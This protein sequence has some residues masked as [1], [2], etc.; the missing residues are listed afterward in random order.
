MIIIRQKQYSLKATRVLA[1]F[2]KTVRRM[3]P[4][5]AKRAALNTEK[6]AFQKIA[7][8]KSSI[9][10][11][12]LDPGAAADRFTKKAVESPIA[13]GSNVAGKA[14]MVAPVPV[15]VK[16]APIGAGGIAAE[17]ILKRKVPVYKN[18]T[19]KLGD[20]YERSAGLRSGIRTVTNAGANSLKNIAAT[21]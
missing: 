13:V 9:E 4:Y 15:A 1:G 16:A 6:K 2:N 19:K 11:S 3:S 5:Q 12:Y 17:A 7:K 20:A 21:V 18:I 8:T 10:N 14:L